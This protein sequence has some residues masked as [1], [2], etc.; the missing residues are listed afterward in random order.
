M[1]LPPYLREK[2]EYQSYLEASRPYQDEHIKILQKISYEYGFFA[3]D[4]DTRV[5]GNYPIEISLG[6]THKD[7]PLIFIRKEQAIE[8]Q[9]LYI[10]GNG[11]TIPL[12]VIVNVD[13]TKYAIFYISRKDVDFLIERMKYWEPKFIPP[14][15]KP[16]HI[17]EPETYVKYIMELS[18]YGEGKL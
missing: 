11:R 14:P 4:A 7:E 5:F 9:N 2:E 8:I 12:R 6:Y 16:N 10:A 18:K 13:K 17:F 1:N 15:S 3:G